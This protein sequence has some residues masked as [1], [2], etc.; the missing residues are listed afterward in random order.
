MSDIFSFNKST[1]LKKSI[2]IILIFGIFIPISLAD[3]VVTTFVGSSVDKFYSSLSEGTSKVIKNY[4]GSEGTTEATLTAGEDMQPMGSIVLV[5][6][7]TKMKIDNVWFTQTQINNYSIK[8]KDRQALNIGIGYRNLS[9]DNS[10][11]VGFNTFFDID[12]KNHQ[13]VSI[14]GELV[15]GPFELIGNYYS[16]L[17]GSITVGDYNE[18]VLDGYDLILGGQIPYLPWA[19]IYYENYSWDSIKNTKDS[20]GN[21]YSAEVRISKNLTL[22]AGIDDNDLTGQDEYIKVTYS[23]PPSDQPT[24]SD[25]LY[26]NKAFENS[27]VSKQMLRKV[28][29]TNKVVVE[30]EGALIVKG[31]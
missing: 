22:E 7:F 2:K 24:I 26:T 5:R 15:S 16:G 14:G 21:K 9:E 30:L 3:N 28:K 1:M 25:K 8:G 6:P 20:A 27:D 4:F 11:F 31:F 13:R 23:Y 29:R 10:Y 12:S 17:T 18:R 19:K